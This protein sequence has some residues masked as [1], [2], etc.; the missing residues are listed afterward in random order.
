MIIP[1]SVKIG[2]HEYKVV[3]RDLDG[4]SDGRFGHMRN[5]SLQIYIDDRTARSQQ[6]ETFIHEML[7]AVCANSH[8]F[9]RGAGEEEE[10][11]VQAIGHGIYEVLTANK[12]LR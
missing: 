10:R 9:P 3:N 6:E 8:L 7:H 5:R 1:A 2:A 12:L 11:I 4:E